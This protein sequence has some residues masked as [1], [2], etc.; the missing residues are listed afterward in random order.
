MGKKIRV[1][2]AKFELKG[3]FDKTKKQTKLTAK[4]RKKHAENMKK[5]VLLNSINYWFI[6]RK[7]DWEPTAEE[8]GEIPWFHSIIIIKGLFDVEEFIVRFY[9]S[10]LLFWDSQVIVQIRAIIY[11]LV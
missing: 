4:Q 9:G 5:F 8:K 2:E 3:K 6:Y 11:V 10:H 1:E 7:T